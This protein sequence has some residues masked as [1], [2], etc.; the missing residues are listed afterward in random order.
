MYLFMHTPFDRHSSLVQ[1]VP[2][3]PRSPP[4][5]FRRLIA[6]Q[7]FW[8]GSMAHGAKSLRRSI[9]SLFG[10]KHSYATAVDSK[11]LS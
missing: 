11:A 5:G 2:L 9:N 3:S 1:F 7:M 6:Q 8:T 10:A 4:G